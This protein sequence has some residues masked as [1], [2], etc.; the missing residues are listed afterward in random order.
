MKKKQLNLDYILNKGNKTEENNYETQKCTDSK[1]T[2]EDSE[3][4]YEYKIVD[5]NNDTGLK[6]RTNIKFDELD[7]D[8]KQRL[9]EQFKLQ[10]MDQYLLDK[11]NLV[12]CNTDYFQNSEIREFVTETLP[13]FIENLKMRIIDKIKDEKKLQEDSESKEEEQQSTDNLFIEVWKVKQN[14]KRIYDRIDHYNQYA[15][16]N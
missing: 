5:K 9:F 3:Q 4:R 7:E 1:E 8:D 6:K 11:R 14:L 16:D 15:L 2:Y 10:I 12:L 13:D